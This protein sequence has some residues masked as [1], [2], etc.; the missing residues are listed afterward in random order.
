M[1]ILRRPLYMRQYEVNRRLSGC[2]GATIA[3]LAAVAEWSMAEM[4]ERLLKRYRQKRAKGYC[5]SLERGRW[6]GE[7]TGI[8]G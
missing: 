7:N 8:G 6:C 4:V 1:M 2:A 5:S 3:D